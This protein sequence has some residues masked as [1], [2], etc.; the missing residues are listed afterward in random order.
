MGRPSFALIAVAGCNSI[1]G[2][3]DPG[4][5]PPDAPSLSCVV[6]GFDLCAHQQ[7]NGPIRFQSDVEIDTNTDCNVVVFVP[8][9][10][11]LCVVYGSDIAV[12]A[13]VRAT[14]DRPFVLAAT[15]A[16]DVTGTIDVSSN[17]IEGIG[18]AGNDKSCAGDETSTPNYFGGAGGSFHGKG[19][20]GGSSNGSATISGQVAQAA[21]TTP[22]TL[23]GG[24]PGRTVQEN[25]SQAVGGGA[26]ALVAGGS[27]TI[28]ATGFVLANGGGG[29]FN[30]GLTSDVTGGAS[31]GMIEL[32]APDIAIHGVVAANGGGGQAGYGGNGFPP[33]GADGSASSSP[34]PGGSGGGGLAGGSGAAGITIDGAPGKNATAANTGGS[35][36]GGGAG[37]ILIDTPPTDTSGSVIS[38]TP[39]TN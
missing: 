23:R 20:D 6:G 38:P 5:A 39:S 31:G 1:L 32:E 25:R 4:A 33:G 37:F 22:S 17:I 9:G 28:G 8:T 15:G 36:G 29:I 13:K 14:G 24:C 35:A 19:G 10:G 34:A 27:I 12:A 30:S 11:S 26:V 7:P 3:G 18:A 21:V 16:I 2:I